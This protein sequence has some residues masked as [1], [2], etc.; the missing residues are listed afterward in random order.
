MP[1]NAERKFKSH[2]GNIKCIVTVVMATSVIILFALNY[3]IIGHVGY[4]KSSLGIPPYLSRNFTPYV[5][6][7]QQQLTKTDVHDSGTW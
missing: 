3:D 6:V 4:I 2:F 1:N 5:N 7:N